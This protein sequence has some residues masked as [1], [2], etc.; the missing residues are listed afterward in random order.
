MRRK[1]YKSL[2]RKLSFVYEKIAEIFLSSFPFVCQSVITVT[3]YHSVFAHFKYC[4]IDTAIL[5]CD[6]ERR[7]HRGSAIIR[8]G[9]FFSN[10]YLFFLYLDNLNDNI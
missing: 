6:Q 2:T 3:R 7:L 1:L 5:L 9:S 8:F 10:F 4:E